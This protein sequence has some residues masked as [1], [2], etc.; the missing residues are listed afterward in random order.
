MHLSD[1]LLGCHTLAGFCASIPG[2]RAALCCVREGLA[3]KVGAGQPREPAAWPVPEHIV[4]RVQCSTS[5]DARQLCHVCRP[6]VVSKVQQMQIPCQSAAAN[7][8]T[9]RRL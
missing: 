6:V 7:T 8:G 3:T 4:A 5:S 9:I 2:F 1:V